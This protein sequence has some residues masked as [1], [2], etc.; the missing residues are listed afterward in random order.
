MNDPEFTEA[1]IERLHDEGYSDIAE[2]DAVA[3]GK[4]SPVEVARQQHMPKEEESVSSVAW[5]ILY[6]A[7][8]NDLLDAMPPALND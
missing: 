3:S 1:V 5:A 7:Y 6:W 4:M 8:R 2:H